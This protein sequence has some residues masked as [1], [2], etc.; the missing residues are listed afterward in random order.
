M[1]S[2]VLKIRMIGVVTKQLKQTCVTTYST[3]AM[4]CPKYES[5]CISNPKPFVYQVQL[6]RPKKLNAINYT[7]WIEFGKCLNDL[8]VNP[9]CRTIILSGKGNIFCSGIDLSELMSIGQKLAMHEDVARKCKALEGTIKLFQDSI[10][11][12]EK[13]PKPVIAAVH[14]ACIG[15]GVDMIS[16]ADIRY[17]S[18]DAYFQIKEVDIGLAADMGTLQRFP[19][20]VGSDSLARELAYTSRKFLATEALQ[21]GFVSRVFENEKILLETSIKIAEDIA[22]KSP[23]AVQSTKLSLIYSRDHSVQEGLDHIAMRNQTM[24]QSEDLVNAAMAQVTK[25]DRPIFSK[26]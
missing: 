14:G 17:C 26:L 8:A 22:S 2:T 4:E 18:S 24:L 21:C 3:A 10:T 19:K 16:A 6:N 25:G 7:M 13:C 11:S 9:E 20:I 12:I 5:L 15:A 1:N 23:V